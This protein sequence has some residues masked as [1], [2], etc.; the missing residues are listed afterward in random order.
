WIEDNKGVV[1]DKGGEATEAVG[2]WTDITER[3]Q[4]EDRLREQAKLL[5]LAQDA[6]MVRDMEDRI[7]FWNHGA[8]NLYGWTA[9]EAQGRKA[10]AFLYQDEP[11]YTA[12]AR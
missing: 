8:E 12:A 3:K 10:S 6:I 7:E 9:A 11:A 2:L 5:D 4:S 1:R